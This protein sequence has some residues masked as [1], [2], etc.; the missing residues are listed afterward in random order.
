MQ[1][2]AL[3]YELDDIVLYAEQGPLTTE[4]QVK[5]TLTVTP[6][7]TEFIDV[8]SQA[9][10]ELNNRADEVARGSSSLA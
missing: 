1:Q 8:V 3:G 9:L 10:E 4:F 5:R 2:R 6:S 7:D